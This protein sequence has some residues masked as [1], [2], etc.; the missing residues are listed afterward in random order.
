MKAEQE[1]ALAKAALE[2]AAKAKI[3]EEPESVPRLRRQLVRDNWLK[4]KPDVKPRP[5]D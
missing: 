4:Q 1:A 5:H 2:A 3:A